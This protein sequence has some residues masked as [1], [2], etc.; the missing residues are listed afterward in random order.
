MKIQT[1]IKELDAQD[2]VN[3][4]SLLEGAPQMYL[5]MNKEIYNKYKEH[6][7]DCVE[8]VWARALLAG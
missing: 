1:T 2:L 7:C 6:C 4:C 5:T 8:E 3:L